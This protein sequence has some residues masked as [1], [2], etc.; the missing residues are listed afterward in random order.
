MGRRLCLAAVLGLGPWL[1]WAG[2][3]AQT[4]AA[5]SG[6][7][8][9]TYAFLSRD[10]ATFKA[11]LFAAES[12]NLPV[13]LIEDEP[14]TLREL[15]KALAGLHGSLNA[16]KH[17]GK[18]DFGPIL[19]RLIDARLLARE[20]RQMG[21]AE[22]P[23][24]KE[25]VDGYRESTGRAILQA[26]VLE[27]VRPD[28]AEVER[29]YRQA[30]REWKVRSVLIP[31]RDD[32][33]KFEAQVK[34]GKKFDDLA[35]QFVAEKKAQGGADPQ[36]LGRNNA[37][38]VVVDALDRMKVGGV[39][40]PL[41]VKDGFAILSLEE[42]RYPENPKARAE[43]V[44]AS[45]AARRKAELKK[46]YDALVKRHSRTDKTLL[47]SLDFEAK[48]PGLAAYKK[49]QRVLARIDDAKPITVAELADAVEKGFYHGVE[50][51]IKEKRVNREKLNVFDGLLSARV[52]PTEVKRQGL[53]ESTEFKERMADSE[54]SLLFSKFVEKAVLPEVKVTEAQLRKYYAD[55]KSSYTYPTF[56]KLESVA[57]TS[58]KGA[59]GA[60]KQ[61]RGGT[62]FKWLNANAEGQV[63]AG[64]RKLGI[65]GT[66]SANTLPKDLATLL[67]GSKKDDYRL[68]ADEA[69]KQY[70]V[71]RLVDVIGASEQPFESVQ[72]QIKQ[73]VF[74][75]SLTAAVK[76][77][78]EKLRKATQVRILLTRIGS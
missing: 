39:S 65:E 38:P 55:H 75:E 76:V 77:W 36:L 68:Y 22:L 14:I 74:E 64:D 19:D 70:Y 13:A 78:A 12:E 66:L 6:G 1:A 26:R 9:V 40:D 2:N 4:P 5:P 35:S 47:K 16:E 43:A 60:V 56:Y 58:L 45:L 11:P 54:N 63:K 57:F 71:I 32:A 30:V 46:F 67:S 17:A 7:G 10:G 73:T 23:E 44:Q 59:E 53:E 3:V 31:N 41:K 69:N 24:Y 37:L 18:K 33:R 62:D 49:D 29:L 50:G 25:A 15:T 34:S 28:A 20:A 51:A 52:V 21:I 8:E 48:K 72:E 27:K 42:V 61:L